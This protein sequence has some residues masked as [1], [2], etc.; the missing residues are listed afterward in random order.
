MRLTQ[1]IR[2][3]TSPAWLLPLCGCGAVNPSP[4]GWLAQHCAPRP[5]LQGV[6]PP[7]DGLALAPTSAPWDG[8]ASALVRTGATYVEAQVDP[9]SDA[10]EPFPQA[11]VYRI[12]TKPAQGCLDALEALPNR[13]NDSSLDSRVIQ[14]RK[15][16]LAI[17]SRCLTATRIGQSVSA[18]ASAGAPPFTAPFWLGQRER[19]EKVGRFEEGY[20]DETMSERRTRTVVL[21]R[22]V[23]AYALIPPGGY[24]SGVACGG[25]WIVNDRLFSA[26]SSDPR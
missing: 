9:G 11:G 17:A 24:G 1:A 26:G 13:L 15:A 23:H 6:R 18:D 4:P 8:I 21:Y 3:V 12:R 25:G 2:R 5:G 7:A 10:Q 16:F 14:Q 20:V 19:K 22:T